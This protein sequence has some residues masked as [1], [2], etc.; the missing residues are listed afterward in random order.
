MSSILTGRAAMFM[1]FAFMGALVGFAA[2]WTTLSRTHSEGEEKIIEHLG[3][4]PTGKLTP[5]HYLIPVPDGH[6]LALAIEGDS[7]SNIADT[8]E[9]DNGETSRGCHFRYQTQSDY[10]VPMA[11]LLTGDLNSSMHTWSDIGLR[12]RISIE[13]TRSDPARLLIDKEWVTPSKSSNG[14]VVYNN[15]TYKYDSNKDRFVES[16]GMTQP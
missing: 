12:G 9:F 7:N 16:G 5:G 4:I 15:K 1:G 13:G 6:F 14:V 8:V 2:A 10:G 3:F 11:R